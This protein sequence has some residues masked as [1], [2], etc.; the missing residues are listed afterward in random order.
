M[1][2]SEAFF[3]SQ[4]FLNLQFGFE[5]KIEYLCLMKM[6]MLALREQHKS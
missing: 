4:I 5:G 2:P 6:N 3:S 1:L